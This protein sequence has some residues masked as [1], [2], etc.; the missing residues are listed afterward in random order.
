M[1]NNSVPGGSRPLQSPDRSKRIF[2]ARVLGPPA[3]EGRGFAAGLILEKCYNTCNPKLG[4]LEFKPNLLTLFI[5]P[6]RKRVKLPI[7]LASIFSELAGAN[8]AWGHYLWSLMPTP[9]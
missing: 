5:V 8:L 2:F 3:R 7:G 4:I 9:S 6:L 1:L